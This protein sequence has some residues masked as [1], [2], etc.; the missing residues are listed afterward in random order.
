MS[1]ASRS[2]NA[3]PLTPTLSPLRGARGKQAGGE[4]LCETGQAL[5]CWRLSLRIDQDAGIEQ[6]L[7]VEGLLGGF[8]RRAEERGALAIVPGAVVAAD[9]VVM[10]DG[11]ARGDD[12]IEA[13]ALDFLPL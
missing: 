12:R 1:D 8:E 9:G 5:A 4:G 3:H 11:A 2:G 13:R 6:A 10:G 7:G